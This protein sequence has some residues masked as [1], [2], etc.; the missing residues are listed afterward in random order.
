MSVV[1]TRPLVQPDCFHMECGD[2]APTAF[3]VLAC[4][5]EVVQ[6]QL[7]I[8]CNIMV[9]INTAPK[10]IVTML[11]PHLNESKL[12]FAMQFSSSSRVQGAYIF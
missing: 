12:T 11:N 4:E 3:L 2:L 10:T 6:N 1:I 7:W 8:D 9:D 5:N